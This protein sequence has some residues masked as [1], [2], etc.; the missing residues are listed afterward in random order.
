[1]AVKSDFAMYEDVIGRLEEQNE[2]LLDEIWKM[3]KALMA[4]SLQDMQSID[5]DGKDVKPNA[6]EP[7]LV[8]MESLDDGDFL[9]AIKNQQL[10]K[11]DDE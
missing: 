9:K 1:M 5:V 3:N 7:D 11:D 10:D 2:R 6:A 8:A 4:R